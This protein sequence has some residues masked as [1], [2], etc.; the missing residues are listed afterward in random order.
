MTKGYITIFFGVDH[1]FDFITKAIC[2]YWRSVQLLK[3]YLTNNKNTESHYDEK[4][5]SLQGSDHAS[6]VIIIPHST[7]L[8]ESRSVARQVSY[9]S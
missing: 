5:R 1:N 8:G 9:F 7:S 2:I 4:S 3:L 6:V